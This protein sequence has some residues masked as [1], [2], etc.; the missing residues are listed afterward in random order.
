MKLHERQ[1]SLRNAARMALMAGAAGSLALMFY[2]G[3]RQPSAILIALFTGWVAS[4]FMG[5]L[6]ADLGSLSPTSARRALHRL[7]AAVAVGSLVV[8]GTNA[9][10]PLSSKGAFLF[11]VVP[12][13]AWLL[14]AIVFVAA[15]RQSRQLP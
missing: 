14:T 9:I 4:P 2:A 8:Y 11:L 1:P 3:R 10:T 13:A 5:L 12:A 7:M 15:A 6:L